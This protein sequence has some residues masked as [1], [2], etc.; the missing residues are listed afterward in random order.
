MSSYNLMWDKNVLN[1]IHYTRE[2]IDIVVHVRKTS[3][4]LVRWITAN[5]YWLLFVSEPLY[6]Y[7][8]I[9]KCSKNE[10][11]IYRVLFCSRFPIVFIY[12]ELSLMFADGLIT[13]YN[14]T[15][16]LERTAP[17]KVRVRNAWRVCTAVWRIAWMKDRW[18]RRKLY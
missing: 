10:S 18:Q 6:G 2:C 14:K 4:R 9:S 12:P 8:R 13:Q 16:I 1:I 5:K 15:E 17:G 3:R 11:C 7:Y